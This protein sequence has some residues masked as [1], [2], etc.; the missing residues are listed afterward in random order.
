MDAGAKLA[1]N[2]LSIVVVVSAILFNAVGIYI[3]K[4]ARIG[5]SNQIR[6][7]I[8]LSV[9]DILN[10]VGFLA[11]LSV[12][13]SGHQALHSTPG[14]VIWMIRAVIY[15]PWY[16]TFFL[17]TI[18][19]FLACNFPFKY[20]STFGRNTMR[21]IIVVMWTVTLIPGPIYCFFNMEKIRVFYDVYVWVALDAI[22]VLLFVVTYGSLYYLKKRSNLQIRHRDTGD[23][24]HR[25]FLVT[26]VILVGFI[27][28]AII[29]DFTMSLLISYAERTSIIAQ[30]GFELWWNVNMLIDPFIYVF[31]QQKVRDT[32][33]GKIRN[34]FRT[35]R[36]RS[37]A[38][39]ANATYTSS[40]GA[41]KKCNVSL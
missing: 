27:F 36:F 32:A 33:L 37:R 20:R 9:A 11:Q 3:L 12:D 17:L 5:K 30:P 29:P 15:H 41:D 22:F 26:T 21:N 19:R 35:L 16:A 1:C 8:S 31:L 28:F 18:D 13:M 7:I 14:L 4:A 24:N 39:S 25:F 23:D 34:C 6:I 38:D 2:V 10:C 40:A